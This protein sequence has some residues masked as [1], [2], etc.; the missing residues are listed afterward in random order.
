MIGMES[1]ESEQLEIPFSSDD[2][3][4]DLCL[5]EI[6]RARQYSIKWHREHIVIRCSGCGGMIA[7]FT[8]EQWDRW[9]SGRFRNSYDFSTQYCDKCIRERVPEK[10]GI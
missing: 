4:I 5:M 6:W 1:T 9:V 10:Y 3:F 2:S 8:K 7:V